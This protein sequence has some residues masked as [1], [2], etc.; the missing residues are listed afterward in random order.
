M[1][2][3]DCL[4]LM[5]RLPDLCVDAVIVDPPYGI[6]ADTNRG[7]EKYGWRKYP[8]TGWDD[9][10][11]CPAIFT[12]IRRCGKRSIIWGGNYFS[13]LL[14]A[15]SKWLIWDKGQT[16]FSL[17]DA[18]LAWCSFP[19]AVR[20]IGL[21]RS[22]AMLDVKVHPTQKSLEV[23]EWCIKQFPLAHQPNTILDP[24]VGSG[25]TLVAA[26]R[27]GRHFLGFEIS[28]AYCRIAR[29]RLAATLCPA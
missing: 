12:A 28:K 3:G 15:S 2:Q 6:K 22:R 27:L 19:G 10:R 13:D 20:R 7:S 29:R 11:P 8:S 23:M 25:T 1:V 21:S 16:N 14:P 18:E 9:K 5:D 17:A 26:K 4:K 24:Y